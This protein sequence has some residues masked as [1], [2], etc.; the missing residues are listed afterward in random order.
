MRGFNALL[1]G[2][3]C[4]NASELQ[5]PLGS[6]DLNSGRLQ[7]DDFAE[8]LVVQIRLVEM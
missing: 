7:V 3:T 8:P 4:G 2:N 6:D 1:L 5:V